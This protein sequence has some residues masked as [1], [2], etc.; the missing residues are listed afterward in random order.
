MRV[1]RMCAESGS[2]WRFPRQA[3]ILGTTPEPAM[4]EGS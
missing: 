1:S 3:N 4:T 2:H